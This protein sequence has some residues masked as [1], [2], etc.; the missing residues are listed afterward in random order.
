MK[1][2]G[3]YYGIADCNG[4]E[5]FNYIPA[6]GIIDLFLEEKDEKEIRDHV[7]F[8]ALRANANSKR[9]AVV[10]R[11]AIPQSQIDVIEEFI[12][13]GD[14]ASA[15]NEVKSCAKEVMLG[16]YGT[17]KSAAE[18]NWKMIPNPDLD[19]YHTK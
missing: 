6:E 17:T 5:S 11:A 3:W 14:Y 1:M 4:L 12:K 9:H 13:A 8:L 10:Y 18:K 15:L 7:Y 19:P 16:T 2:E